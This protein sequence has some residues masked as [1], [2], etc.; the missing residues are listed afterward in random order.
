MSLFK[1]KAALG[2]VGKTIDMHSHILPGVDDG[3]KNEGMSRGMLDIAYEHGIKTIIATPH[4]M[5][6]Q[7]NASPETVMGEALKLMQYSD[8]M[9]YGIN[10]LTGNEVY[11]HDEVPDLLESGKILTLAGSCCVLIE[12]SPMDDARYIWNALHEVQ[13]LGYT[14]ILAHVERY[15]SL[16]KKPYDKIKELRDM[17]VLIQVN[18]STI[19]GVFGKE[20]KKLALSLLEKELV[21][22]IGT[23]SHSLGS[24]A[25]RL[26]ECVKTLSKV[27]SVEYIEEL[28]YTNAEHYILSKN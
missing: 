22:F 28:L 2:Y 1:K 19:D 4:F 24:R 27:C 14:P 17:G 10:I 16:C 20:Q 7:N 23:D 12:F 9:G 11:Y 6:G 8:E 3:S 18:S 25:P 13:T 26:E 5:P 15:H 21:D